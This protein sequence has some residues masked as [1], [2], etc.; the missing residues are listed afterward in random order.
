MHCQRIMCPPLLQEGGGRTRGAELR[1]SPVQ[2]SIHTYRTLTT[3]PYAGET[4]H[5]P[6]TRPA[7]Q[8]NN[9]KLRTLTWGDRSSYYNSYHDRLHTILYTR[10]L[11]LNTLLPLGAPIQPGRALLQTAKRFVFMVTCNDEIEPR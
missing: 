9:K 11:L 5:Q 7:K 1:H 4:P 2:E 10:T 8:N 6:A 3:P